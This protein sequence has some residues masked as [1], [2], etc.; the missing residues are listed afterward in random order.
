[1]KKRNKHFQREK[2]FIQLRKKLSKNWEAQRNLG[3]KELDKPQFIGYDAILEPREDIQNRNDAWVFWYICENFAT[4]HFSK[5][6]SEFYWNKK[7]SKYYT[8][9]PS[10]KPH[11]KS[12]HRSV[13]LEL[14]SEIKKWFTNSYKYHYEGGW[15]RDYCD[16]YSC[17]VPDFYWEIVYRKSYRTKVKIFDPILQQEEAEI[18]SILLTNFYHEYDI[19]HRKAPKHFRKSLNR[20]QRAK[21]KQTL[22]N[23]VYKNME[24]DFEDDYRGADWLWW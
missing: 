21:S 2:E 5:K 15:H 3:W 18:E 14:P 4:I 11:I 19:R 8:I 9:F 23:I 20:S 24:C 13:Y 17:N 22:H 16:Y 1:M 12:I 6:I 10:D 7:K